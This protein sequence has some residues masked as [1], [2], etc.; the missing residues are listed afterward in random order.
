MPKRKSMED[1]FLK[2][3]ERLGAKKDG[4]KLDPLTNSAIYLARLDAKEYVLE[5][6]EGD[7]SPPAQKIR[8]IVS[9]RM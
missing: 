3:A 7:M 8:A 4:A 9:R 1:V 2:L 6:I 5:L